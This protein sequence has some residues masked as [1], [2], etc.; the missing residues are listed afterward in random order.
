M[1]YPSSPPGLP[2][3][4]VIQSLTTF[5]P[6]GSSTWLPV[7]STSSTSCERHLG[8]MRS[9]GSHAKIQRPQVSRSRKLQLAQSLVAS[10]LSRYQL[11][12]LRCCLSALR[13]LGAIGGLAMLCLI[14]FASLFLRKRGGPKIPKIRKASGSVSLFDHQEGRPVPGVAEAAVVKRPLLYVRGSPSFPF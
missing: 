3:R 12:P 10:S 9:P 11:S 6:T 2:E 4:P 7:K 13:L 5:T 8:C 14:G 1:L